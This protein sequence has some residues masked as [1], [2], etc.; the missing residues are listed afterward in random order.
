[1]NKRSKNEINFEVWKD[2]ADGGRVYSVNVSGKHGWSAGY[3]KEVDASEITVRFWQEIY[4]EQGVLVELHEKYPVDS[5]H[6]SLKR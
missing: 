1:M 6:R 4:N 5:G 3:F 2:L